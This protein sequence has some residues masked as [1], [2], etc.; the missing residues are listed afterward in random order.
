MDASKL[1]ETII[2]QLPNFLGLVLCILILY[3]LLKRQMII[4]DKLVEFI[5]HDKLPDKNN[6]V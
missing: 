2:L 1:I 6:G 4:N 3:T 5:I